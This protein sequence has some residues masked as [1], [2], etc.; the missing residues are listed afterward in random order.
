MLH[1]NFKET[2][3]AKLWMMKKKSLLVVFSVVI[4]SRGKHCC[5]QKLI[6]LNI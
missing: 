6:Q 2:I 3:I 4:D 1:V 5:L